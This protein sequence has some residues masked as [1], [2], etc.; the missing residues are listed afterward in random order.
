MSALRSAGFP[1]CGFWDILVPTR[2]Q[3]APT[4]NH[5]HLLRGKTVGIDATTPRSQSC[6]EEASFESTPA[7]IGM[8]VC[9]VPVSSP[10][11]V[12]RPMNSPAAP[13]SVHPNALPQ[14]CAPF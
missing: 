6:D 14:E 3:A 11:R 8:N 7:P 1:A 5:T 13:C 9:D 10:D 12:V 2:T 4:F